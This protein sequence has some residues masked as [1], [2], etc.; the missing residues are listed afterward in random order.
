MKK[1]IPE[2]YCKSIYDIDYKKLKDKNIK[3]LLFDLDNT[4]VPYPKK[5][6]TED[7]KKL[8]QK[9]ETM[10]FRVIIFSN[11]TP[12]RLDKFKN[13]GV[14][15]YGL[16]RKPHKKNFYKILT[17]YFYQKKEV[18][19]IGDQL[20]TDILGGNKVGIHTLLVDPLGPKDFIITKLSRIAELIVF[21]ILSKKQI[22]Q[23][24]VYYYDR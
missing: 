1:L 9:L 24:G 5:E 14:E 7:L 16:S 19:I 21:N 8:F 12:N 3:C 11:T 18:C 15:V 2:M 22:H 4:C 23:K 17:K 13:I 10:D 20:F 6:P